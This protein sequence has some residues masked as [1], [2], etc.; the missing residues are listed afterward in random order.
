VGPSASTSVPV[1]PE[2]A[3]RTCA[4]L[5]EIS[6][7][8][9]GCA[10]FREAGGRGELLGS[11]GDGEGWEQA[12]R[13]L[14]AA[15]DAAGG[16]AASHAHISTGDG[17]VFLVRAEGLLAVAAAERLTLATLMV[18]DLRTALKDLARG[19]APR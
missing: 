8:M 11:N 4:Y 15:V 16:E 13:E 9:R 1:S 12:A 2:D 19:R 14:I 7:E 6:P 3:A 18:F 5:Y 10:I 17:E